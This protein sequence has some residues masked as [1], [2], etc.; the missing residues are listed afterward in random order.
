VTDDLI[1]K[2]GTY[3]VG[4]GIY[5]KYDGQIPFSRFVEMWK[6]GTWKDVVA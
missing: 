4:M 6:M 1:E 2:L 5:D 3:Y